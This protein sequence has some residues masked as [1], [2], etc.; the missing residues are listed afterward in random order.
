MRENEMFLVYIKTI[1]GKGHEISMNGIEI[2][3]LK[4]RGLFGRWVEAENT[5]KNEVLIRVDHI[6]SIK[7][8]EDN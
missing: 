4:D 1:D 7:F 2:D 3:N 5:S 6:A 8:T